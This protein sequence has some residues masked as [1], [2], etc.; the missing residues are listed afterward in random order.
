LS[1]KIAPKGCARFLRSG[2]RIFRESEFREFV[3]TPEVYT[4]G[5]RI[6]TNSWIAIISR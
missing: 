1:R 5:S 3:T 6:K 2:S 4:P